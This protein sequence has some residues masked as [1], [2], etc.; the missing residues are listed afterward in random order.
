MVTFLRSPIVSR[1]TNF[2][3]WLER[4]PAPEETLWT[5]RCWVALGA[6]TLVAVFFCG[7][8]ILYLTQGHQAYQTNAED[9]GDYG[10][11]VVEHCAWSVLASDDLQYHFGYELCE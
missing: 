9:L 5:R 10:S 11:G 3:Q 6:V 1:V 7:Y 2:W 4:Y 8:F